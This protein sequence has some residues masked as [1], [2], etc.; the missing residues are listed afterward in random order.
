MIK[1][2]SEQ[3]LYIPHLKRVVSINYWLKAVQI[4]SNF[5]RKE[6]MKNDPVFTSIVKGDCKGI[7]SD[8]EPDPDSVQFDDYELH[9][10]D[11]LTE[12][13]PFYCY[14]LAYLC[15]NSLDNKSI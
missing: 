6:F 4:E 3:W 13:H 12:S 11:N 7:L 2:M 5:Q 8:T 10:L 15:T 1:Y 14:N 9:N